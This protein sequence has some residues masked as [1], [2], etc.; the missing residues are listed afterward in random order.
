METSVDGLPSLIPF[1]NIDPL[2][3][4]PNPE[5]VDIP[6][7][8]TEDEEKRSMYIPETIENGSC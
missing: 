5:Q 7:A 1:F 2:S 3:T 8:N 4:I 6:E